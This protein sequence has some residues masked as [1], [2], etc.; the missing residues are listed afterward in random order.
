MPTEVGF[1]LV[2][3]KPTKVVAKRQSPAETIKQAVYTVSPGR[4][5]GLPDSRLP[6]RVL[7]IQG[8]G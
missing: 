7:S 2:N 6:R 1:A 8:D 5:V 4:I 3:L